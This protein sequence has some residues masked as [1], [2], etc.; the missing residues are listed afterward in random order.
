M[1]RP[2]VVI[3]NKMNYNV[4][5]IF[6]LFQVQILFS[7]RIPSY[8]KD[9]AP[10]INSNCVECHQNGGLGPF[11]LTNYEEVRSKIKMIIYVT[12]SGY[13]PPWQADPEF[14]SFKN[15]RFLDSNSKNLILKWAETGLNKGRK[16]DYKSALES[17]FTLGNP[18]LILSISKQYQLSDQSI[19]DYRFFNIP[20][21]IPEDTYLSAVEFVPGNKRVIHH[22]RIMIDT[23]NQ[24]RGIDGLSEFDPKSLEFQKKPLAD[25]FLY[26]W[27]PGNLPVSYP[28]GTGKKIFKNSDLILNIHYA[29]TS[30]KEIDSS[31]IKL[32]FAKDKIQKEINVLTI[33]EG[34]IANQPFF[35]PANT[36]PTFYVSYTLKDSINIVSIMPHM[37]FIGDS[38]KALAVTPDGTAVPIIKIDHWDFNWQST[39]LFDKPQFLPKGTVLLITATFDNSESNPE[40]PNQPP[41]DIGYGWDSTDEMMNFIIYY[42]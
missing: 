39:Y 41:K 9:I 14:R 23:T 37:H 31:Q 42:Y 25:E 20:T 40:N 18:D 16:K 28:L 11:P 32:Y 7:Q 15:E 2:L 19:E 29:P 6:F 13:M 21:D 30:R 4:T 5:L 27:V 8:Y 24:I 38:F 36:K 34:D 35:I 10:I 17:K 33:R 12:Q 22:S 1:F 3:S 26:G